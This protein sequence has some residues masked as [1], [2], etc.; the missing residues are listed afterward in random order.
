MSDFKASDYSIFTNAIST[1]KN[2]NAKIDSGKASVAEVKNVIGNDS[3]FMG[4]AANSCRDGLNT[5]S[6][7]LETLTTNFNSIATYLDQASAN[8]QAGDQAAQNNVLGINSTQFTSNVNTGNANRDFIYSY[9]ISK[10]YSKAGALGIISNIRSESSYKPDVVGDSGTSYGLCQWHKG[11]WDNLKQYCSDNGKD[12]SSLE[13]Q[14]D[15][16]MYEL[17]NKYPKLNNQLKNAGNSPDAAFD[18]AYQMTVQFERPAGMETSGTN[19]GNHARV[20]L[21]EAY[22]N[23]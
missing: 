23:A 19:R 16:L 1:T 9:L 18:A 6:S 14:L 12:V 5:T 15:F 4:P 3:V 20:Q 2:L 11:R 8:Y 13:G 10:G 22:K 17:E 21:W 7:K